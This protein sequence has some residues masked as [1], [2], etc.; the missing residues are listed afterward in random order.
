[1]SWEI[2]KENYEKS[3]AS[4]LNNYMLLTTEVAEVAQEMRR[5]F[6]ITHKRVQQGIDKEE[7]FKLAKIA[8]K[9][10]FGKEFADCLA[11]I[12]KIAN[13]FDVDLEESYYAKMEDVGNRK[14]KDIKLVER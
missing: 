2:N 3:R 9:E 13:F 12:A 4:P 11:Y 6:N 7:A 1:M 10:D 14:N 5:A 8:I